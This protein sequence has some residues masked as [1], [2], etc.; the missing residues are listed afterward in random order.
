[1]SKVGRPQKSIDVEQL[2]KLAERQWT[3]EQIAAFFRVSRDTIERRFAEEVRQSKQRG[4]AKLL[5]KQFDVAMQGNVNMLIWLG[6]N[7][8][9]QTDKNEEQMKAWLREELKKVNNEISIDVGTQRTV[10]AIPDESGK[11]S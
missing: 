5:D 1:M 10:I 7:Y 3:V 8:L 4:A 11:T 6:K 2:E 9:G